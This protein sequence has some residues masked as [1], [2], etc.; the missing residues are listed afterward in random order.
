VKSFAALS[1]RPA[2]QL[3]HTRPSGGPTRA[4]SGHD[5]AR[6]EIY[7]RVRHAGRSDATA[8]RDLARLHDAVIAANAERGFFITAR[9][10]TEEAETYA[11]SAPIDL[12]DGKRL[13]KALNQ[14]KKHVLFAPLTPWQSARIHFRCRRSDHHS[15]HILLRRQQQPDP[16]GDDR[17]RITRARKAA[18]AL[19]TS[20]PPVSGP[21]VPETASADLPQRKPRVLRIIARPPIRPEEADAVAGFGRLDILVNN[22]GAPPLGGIWWG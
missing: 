22:D 9:G 4:G 1:G 13:V 8:I 19:F 3:S 18:E 2:A 5:Q 10:F 21:S 11:E 20:K 16:R 7:H 12:F 14:S 15:G 17:E 6:A